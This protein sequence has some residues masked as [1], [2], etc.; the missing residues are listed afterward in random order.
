M[1]SLIEG[2]WKGVTIAQIVQYQDSQLLVSSFFT[3]AVLKLKNKEHK[4][5]SDL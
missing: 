2:G 5:S 4:D 3:C 1:V